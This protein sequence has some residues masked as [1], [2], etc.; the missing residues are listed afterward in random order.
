[1]KL[2]V[3]ENPEMAHSPTLEDRD[4]FG[5]DDHCTPCAW[6]RVWVPT[7]YLLNKGKKK[8]ERKEMKTFPHF[9][10]KAANR[11]VNFN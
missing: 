8:E 3:Y 4:W 1:M 5:L 7:S 10:D 9:I 6:N 11:N 2:F